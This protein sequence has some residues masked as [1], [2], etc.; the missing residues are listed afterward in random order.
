M[1]HFLK[2]R[3]DAILADVEV[4]FKN[5]TWGR[6]PSSGGIRPKLLHIHFLSF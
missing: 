6:T 5:I 2:E 4:Q 3:L 1:K